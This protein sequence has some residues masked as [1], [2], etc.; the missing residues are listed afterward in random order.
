LANGP[1][2]SARAAKATLVETAMVSNHELQPTLNLVGK[3]EATQSVV[4]SPES[5][6]RIEAIKVNNN[7]NVVKDEIL[8]VLDTANAEM[9]VKEAQLTLAEE[10]RIL[11]EYERLVEKKAITQTSFAGQ[12]AKVQIAEVKLA[13]AEHSLDQLYVKAPFTGTT[14]FIDFSRGKMVSS[15]TELFTIDDLSV[16][17][18]DILVP[19]K[20]LQQ[21]RSGLTVNAMSQ[22]WPGIEFIGKLDA[23]DT[24][25]NPETLN[26]TARVE[27]TNSEQKLKPGMLMNVELEF[28]P[29]SQPIIPVQ[30]LEYS[31]SKRFVYLV[32]DDNRVSRTE[33]TLGDRINEQVA[34]TSGID[35]G[36]RVVVTGTVNMRDGLLV[37]DI[38]ASVNTAKLGE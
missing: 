5:A 1:S 23:I 13:S 24:R 25:I 21:I 12:Q 11:G 33:V 29:I 37:K 34:I 22:A 7:Q 6:G 30:A 20:Y 31:G 3:L 4:I 38:S 8:V 10:K 15:S 26:M 35:I 17:Y 16:M 18:V 14:G 28:S 32:N 9:L 27:F 36:D 2:S 19:E